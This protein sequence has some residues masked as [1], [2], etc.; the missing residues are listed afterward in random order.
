M[1][2]T[3]TPLP[4][5]LSIIRALA[6]IQFLLSALGLA[7][8][9]YDGLTSLQR[10]SDRPAVTLEIHHPRQGQVTRAGYDSLGTSRA[11]YP[12]QLVPISSKVA[13]V[14]RERNLGKRLGLLLLGMTNHS[15]HRASVPLMLYSMLTGL[16]IYRILHDLHLE[17]PFT[18]V[19]ARRI[20]WL[21]LLMIGI[22]VYQY[23]EFL[24]L[25][26]IV[27]PLPMPGEQGIVTRY[28]VLDPGTEFG[29]WK[30]GLV[31]LVVAAVYRRGVMMAR[32][33]ELTV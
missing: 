16:F 3:Q 10:G 20:R 22:D 28:L 25:R 8:Y 27:P 11:R 12:H 5:F 21:G 17:S 18:E 2:A 26:A 1:A 31:L 19:N 32:E 30:F 33:A 9:G 13:L 23:L 14:Y 7:L 15:A 24:Y 6:Q 4:L 29:G